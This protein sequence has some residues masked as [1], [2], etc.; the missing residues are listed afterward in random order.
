MSDYSSSISSFARGSHAPSFPSMMTL[1]L[2]RHSKECHW[3]MG[4]TMP[5]FSPPDRLNKLKI[6]F[7]TCQK[8]IVIRLYGCAFKERKGL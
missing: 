2:S 7:Q 8:H 6:N 4:I 1:P 3:L 5:M